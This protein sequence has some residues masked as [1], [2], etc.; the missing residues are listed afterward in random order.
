MTARNS[1]LL[2]EGGSWLTAEAIAV[3]ERSRE[4]APR[5]KRRR[6]RIDPNLIASG[7]NRRLE[8]GYFDCVPRSVV[9][10]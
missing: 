1:S 6:A 3:A 2:E 10:L 4:E 9:A 7:Y 5:R 8:T